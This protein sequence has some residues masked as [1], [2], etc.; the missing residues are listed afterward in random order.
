MASKQIIQTIQI[1]HYSKLNGIT[2]ESS[3]PYKTAT[4]RHNK[5]GAL[6]R[7]NAGSAERGRENLRREAPRWHILHRGRGGRNDDGSSLLQRQREGGSVQRK[8]KIGILVSAEEGDGEIEMVV[9]SKVVVVDS[10]TLGGEWLGG[11]DEGER[12]SVGVGWTA[13]MESRKKKLR[14]WLWWLGYLEDGGGGDCFGDG[15]Y[16]VEGGD[17]EVDDD[18]DCVLDRRE[19]EMVIVNG[20]GF[21]GG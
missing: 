20:G 6:N 17:G 14:W 16:G 8:H 15:G 13:V 7:S 19:G 5:A 2:S 21:S 18:E 3:V 9:A 4:K 1:A 10:V 11:V 12:S